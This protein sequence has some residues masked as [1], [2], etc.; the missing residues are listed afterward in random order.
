MVF[1]VTTQLTRVN[2]LFPV[3]NSTHMS[4]VYVSSHVM[5]VFGCVGNPNTKKIPLCVCVSVKE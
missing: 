5:C 4:G 1:S 3:N 2:D